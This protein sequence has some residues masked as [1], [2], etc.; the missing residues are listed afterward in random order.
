MARSQLS[1]DAQNLAA[2]TWYENHWPIISDVMSDIEPICD[3]NILRSDPRLSDYI[4][5]SLTSAHP[6]FIHRD[7][8]HYINLVK[9]TSK[10]FITALLYSRTLND[11]SVSKYVFTECKYRIKR[12]KDNIS[13]DRFDGFFCMLAS[14]TLVYRHQGTFEGSVLFGQAS[15]PEVKNF[16]HT[17]LRVLQHGPGAGDQN[18]ICSITGN[19]IENKTYYHPIKNEDIIMNCFEI[20]HAVYHDNSS[21]YYNLDLKC[22]VKKS[23]SPSKY[24]HA[25]IFN[26]FNIQRWIELL[27]CIIIDVS[28]HDTLHKIV[29]S[30]KIDYWIK[31]Y[32]N[33]KYVSI[34]YAWRSK[35]NY[36]EI[37]N[38]ILGSCP[39][40]SASSFPDYQ[41]FLKLHRGECTPTPDISLD[42]DLFGST[43]T[44]STRQT[45]IPCTEEI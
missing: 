3:N 12:G 24:I 5:I 41:T 10:L 23:I 42:P 4:E 43:K 28:E 30:G 38:W 34:P 22:L 1:A 31:G 11:K 36:D 9:G 14:D 21:Y 16:N 35:D 26:N 17:M 40:L 18:L 37:I 19:I 6:Y 15:N 29:S 7:I 32:Q 44:D 27:S 39:H 33:S 13:I 25:C 45:P 20:H 8:F 2:R